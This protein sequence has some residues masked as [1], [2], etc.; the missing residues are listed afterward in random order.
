MNAT[1]ARI[2]QQ[3]KTRGEEIDEQVDEARLRSD[4]QNL[5]HQFYQFSGQSS[6]YATMIRALETDLAEAS[7]EEIQAYV[8][9]HL[10]FYRGVRNKATPNSL[11]YL[12]A[13]GECMSLREMYD[14]LSRSS[15]EEDQLV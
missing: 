14:G 7:L 5:N 11:N 13:A 8:K 12:Q 1:N 6:S 4:G 10:D 3:W 2:H 9:E 15:N